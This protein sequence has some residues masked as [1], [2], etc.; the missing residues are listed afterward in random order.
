[1][2]VLIQWIF[3]KGKKKLINKKLSHMF[4]FLVNVSGGLY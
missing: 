4:C 1:M 3:A 2:C